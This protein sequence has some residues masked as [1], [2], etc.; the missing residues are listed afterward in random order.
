MTF[1]PGVVGSNP[2][3][4]STLPYLVDLGNL[5]KLRWLI[6]PARQIDSNVDSASVSK[7]APALN[8]SGSS[9]LETESIARSN[10][11][12]FD[13]RRSDR[14]ILAPGPMPSPLRP[15]AR[16]SPDFSA[17]PPRSTPAGPQPARS[18]TASSTLPPSRIRRPRPR[19]PRQATLHVSTRSA[20]AD[21]DRMQPY[22][23]RT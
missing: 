23:A 5:P 8:S 16:R 19:I 10:R 22:P 4:P 18:R 12:T 3:G 20:A 7:R 21:S 6:S 15:A 9:L 17:V 14:G 11:P 2:T 1:N 13:W